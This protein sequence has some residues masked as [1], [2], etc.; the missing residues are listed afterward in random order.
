MGVSMRSNAAAKAVSLKGLNSPLTRVS[1]RGHF[2]CDLTS[3]LQLDILVLLFPGPV[4]IT[5]RVFP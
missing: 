2:T 5:G 4:V 1:A 3:C